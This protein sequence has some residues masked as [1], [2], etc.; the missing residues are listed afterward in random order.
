MKPITYRG[1]EYPSRKALAEALNMTTSNV[2][3]AIRLGTVDGL[4]VGMAVGRAM[5]SAAR[6]QPVA[7]FG[8]SWPSQKDAAETLGRD[9]KTV[10]AAL[11]R[12]T[13]ERLVLRVLGPAEANE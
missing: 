3:R 4:G 11:Q 9:P 1:K 6:C 7:A 12:G 8:W 5:A 2:H 10:C 13:F